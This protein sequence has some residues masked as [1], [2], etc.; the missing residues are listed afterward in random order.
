LTNLKDPVMSSEE[1]KAIVQRWF[2]ALEQRKALQIVEQIFAQDFILH[3]PG[4]PPDLPAGPLGVLRF[5]TLK[6]TIFPDLCTR[7]ED[8]LA[9]G[10]KVA[11]RYS[12]SG[13]QHWNFPHTKLY[14][15]QINFEGASLIRLARGMIV[16]AW[17]YV[18]VLADT[19]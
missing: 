5:L 17:E 11:V 14:S 1:N 16:E 13:T 6:S 2:E 18:N 3:D 4:A 10:D 15:K 19:V 9:E 12:M 7:L 8:I